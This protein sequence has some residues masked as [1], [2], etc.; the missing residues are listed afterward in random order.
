MSNYGNLPAKVVQLIMV[1]WGH[2]ITITKD[3]YCFE[4]TIRGH[5]SIPTAGSWFGLGPLSQ[6]AKHRDENRGK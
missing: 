2:E 4:A 3:N 6:G 1:G 5:R